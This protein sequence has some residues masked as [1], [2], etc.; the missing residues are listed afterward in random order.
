VRGVA[1]P[2]KDPDPRLIAAD[3]TATTAKR[4]IDAT[5]ALTAE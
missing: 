3:G 4:D 2:S 5:N 1:A